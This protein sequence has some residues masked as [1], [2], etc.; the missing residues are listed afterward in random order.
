MQ[1]VEIKKNIY[2]VGAVDWN[3]RNFHGYSLARQGTTYNAYLVKDEKTALFDSVPATHTE[4]FLHTLRSIIDPAAIDYLVVN[5]VEPDHSG[6]LP[7]LV[8]LVKPE[9]IFCSPVGKQ[10][11]LSHY[12]REDW[13]YEVVPSGQ[14]LNLGQR[15]V[16]FLETR[17]LHWPDSMFS[18]LPED[19]LLISSDAFGQNWAASERFD[20]QVD[21]GA[22]LD[23]SANYYANIILPF[24]PLVQKLLAK[25]KELGWE[26]EMIAPDHG[27]IWRS[28][29]AEIVAKYDQWSRQIPGRKAVIVYDTMWKS[30]E[31][32]AKAIA[33]GLIKTGISTRIMHL[34]NAHHS[35]VMPEIMHAQAVLFGSSTHNNGMLPL[36][37]DMLTYMKGLKPQ[38]KIGA[39]FG[40]Y[41]WSGEAVKQITEILQSAKVEIVVDG[42]RVKNVPTV[43]DLEECMEFGSKVAREIIARVPE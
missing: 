12:H 27:F 16:H 9:K 38:G 23:L 1:P 35:D 33:E 3:L 5:H 10:T 11:L 37:A 31:T 8:E 20:D 15:T 39:V 6:A 4:E 40:S 24:S 13:P 29:A 34:K 28:H 17:M 21:L 36:V 32:M 7:K 42:L 30:T 19:K 43:L 22:L 41:G 2:W 26:I 25:I 18:F 14:T